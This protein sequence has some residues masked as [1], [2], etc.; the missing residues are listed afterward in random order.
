MI[1][2]DE[3]LEAQIAERFAAVG[4]PYVA[5]NSQL[6]TD[7]RSQEVIESAGF[8]WST[9]PRFRRSSSC[10]A[11]TGRRSTRR[12]RAARRRTTARSFRVCGASSWRH[13]RGLR[14]GMDDVPPRARIRDRRTPRH[15]TDRH[16]GVSPRRRLPQRRDVHA[17]PETVGA[18]AQVPQPLEAT[19]RIAVLSAPDP[20]EVVAPWEH[21]PVRLLK[22]RRPFAPPQAGRHRL[23][24]SR[25]GD[26]GVGCQPT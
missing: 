8:L 14:L 10:Y 17:C 24:R 5:A 23:S 25:C 9:S 16:P 18:G 15:P 19:R 26:C 11:S 6:R 13:E 4:R 7:D 12:R 2:T 1:V 22:I 21:D 20:R 3:A